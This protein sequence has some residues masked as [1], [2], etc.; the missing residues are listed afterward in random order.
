MFRLYARRMFVAHYRLGLVPV[1]PDDN[2]VRC[3]CND[4]DDVKKSFF[5]VCAG[6][7]CHQCWLDLDLLSIVC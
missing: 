2:T 7:H 4:D 5:V 3:V 6:R 1:I